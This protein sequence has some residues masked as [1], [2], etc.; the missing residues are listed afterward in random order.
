MRLARHRGGWVLLLAGLSLGAD[1][2]R[3]PD[4]RLAVTLPAGWRVA[5][6]PNAAGLVQARSIEKDAFMEVNAVAKVDRT[7]HGL[8]RYAERC[9]AAADHT[10]RLTDR[11]TDDLRPVTL[12]GRPGYVCSVVGALNGQRRVFVKSYVETD[13]QYV[14]VTCWTT[15]SH[16][17]AADGDFHFLADH[18]VDAV[19]AADLPPPPP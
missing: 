11:Q 14:E 9:R 19:P 4:G 15:P 1:V 5:H 2:A 18:V 6:L 7:D 10:S 3:T 8:L 12:G 17:D 16:A 13:R